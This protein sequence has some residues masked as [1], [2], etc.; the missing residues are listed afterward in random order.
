[1]KNFRRQGSNQ[2]NYKFH[3]HPNESLSF[4]R[5]ARHAIS[6]VLFFG[7]ALC[8]AAPPSHAQGRLT[9]SPG[10]F[11]FGAVPV[12][13]STTITITAKNVGDRPVVLNGT[14]LTSASQFALSGLKTP[15]TLAVAQTLTFTVKFSPTLAQSQSSTL[16]LLSNA[17]NTRA[18]VWMN[19]TGTK[20]SVTAAPTRATFGN[21]A[22]GVTNS[23]TIQ[24]KNAGTSGL[25][26]SAA[27]ATG[28]G[29]S[30]SGITLPLSLAVGK[31]ATFNIAFSPKAAGSISGTASVVGNFPAITIPVT[32]TGVSGSRVISA[33]AT[34]EN[35][36]NVT[37][38]S[39]SSATVTLTDTG[40][41]SVTISGLS[42]SGTGISASGAVNTTLNPGQSTPITVRFAPTTTGSISGSVAVASN[43]TNSPLAILVTGAGVAA[44]AHSVSLNWAASNSSGVT[45]YN[46]YRS[47][48]SGGPYTKLDAAPVTALDYTDTSVQS[49]TDYFYVLT[50]V[51]SNGT[52]SSYS[53]QVSV[54]VP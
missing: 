31:T 32:G 54:S 30:V 46:V 16:T 47:T 19:G 27:T 43:A 24:L 41:S 9:L 53:T 25:T 52:Q 40:N 10:Y 49:G 37:V 8:L 26:I 35:F 14:T 21:V 48:V 1:M 22:V 12:N 42:F 44:A 4:G 11:N 2:Q 13:T 38:G 28:S 7:V 33:S 23:Q 51:A 18:V 29:F 5:A 15:A 50:S 36:G 34:T 6:V 3:Q 45:G 20:S 17:A 39:S